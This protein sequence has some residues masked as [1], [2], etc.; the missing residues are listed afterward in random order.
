[1]ISLDNAT[2]LV[3]VGRI[4][5]GVIQQIAWS[6]SGKYLAIG[7]SIGI[8]NY[9]INPLTKLS[10]I[11]TP[12]GVNAL[13][14]GKD[15]NTIIAA[16]N[17]QEKSL[18]IFDLSTGKSLIQFGFQ[19]VNFLSYSATTNVVASGDAD[20]HVRLWNAETGEYIRML[21]TLMW[22]QSMIISQDGNQVMI[23]GETGYY[24]PSVLE[25]WEANTGTLQKTING[26]VSGSPE[27][28]AMSPDN[29]LLASAGFNIVV[30]SLPTASNLYIGSVGGRATDMTFSTDS[31]W[32]MM[33]EYDGTIQVWKASNGA[34]ERII[35]A[36]ARSVISI[37]CQPNGALVATAGEDG[38]IHL[39]DTND[40]KIMGSID[41]FID[42]GSILVSPD[43]TKVAS[44][45][46]NKIYLWN[47]F[48]YE[49]VSIFEFPTGPVYSLAFSPDN[50][51]LAAGG[52]GD[53]YEFQC[54]YGAIYLWDLNRQTLDKKI[55]G[56]SGEINNLVF[57]QD[58]QVLIST[59]LGD[60]NVK[61]W[62]VSTG[63]LQLDF[64]E[65]SHP[66]VIVISP[67][68]D[69]FAVITY[70]EIHI[71]YFPS[72]DT[73]QTIAR[74]Y[75]FQNCGTFSLDGNLLIVSGEN[76]DIIGYDTTIGSKVF[77]LK[78]PFYVKPFTY[79][80]PP[81][82]IDLQNLVQGNSLVASYNTGQVI[83]W[84]IENKHMTFSYA[85]SNT[86]SSIQL[87]P[88]GWILLTNSN[89]KG[90]IRVWG[91][92]P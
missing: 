79:G 28:L 29:L 48:T 24:N 82:A 60:D 36:H 26:P 80:Y 53:A 12:P 34:L 1:M 19:C 66:D 84:N 73:V 72:G 55:Y 18:R 47:I 86:G 87:T 35:P 78:Y 21:D 16:L 71:R 33:G 61:S 54:P 89:F 17:T 5:K 67:A 49:L 56:H 39:W 65:I 57:S 50:H 22:I 77:Q 63:E 92:Q 74:Q 2:Q 42:N 25:V 70:R 23:G 46:L 91:I 30:R 40:W 58:S 45:D 64:N 68:G 62:D 13:T 10:F 88:D 41:G 52:C 69:R 31:S 32:L 9:S 15:D 90:I 3:E 38:F 81:A 4:G 44:S 11:D 8:Y 6:P 85:P 83:F 76:G 51:F 59:G 27:H 7:T 20:N 75:N 37:A 43:G 14:F